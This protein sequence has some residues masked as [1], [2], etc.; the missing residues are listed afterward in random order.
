ML[1][2]NQYGGSSLLCSQHATRG[3]SFKAAALSEQKL[4]IKVIMKDS[5]F[6]PFY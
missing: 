5:N 6:E 2:P 3:L 4:V 1:Y